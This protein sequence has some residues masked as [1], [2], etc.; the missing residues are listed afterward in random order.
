MA[1]DQ[2]V[3][4]GSPFKFGFFAG[5]GFFFASVLMSVIS[6]VVIALLGLGT[7]GALISGAHTVQNAP[8]K[9]ITPAMAASDNRPATE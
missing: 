3:V 9:N 5:L 1:K 4:F 2:T 8:T 7:I 6:F